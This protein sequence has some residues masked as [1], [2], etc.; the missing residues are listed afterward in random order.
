MHIFLLK[1]SE[2]EQAV[3]FAM[4]QMIETIIYALSS[5]S[6]QTGNKPRES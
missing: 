5:L 4:N 2:E 3:V 1:K 6:A